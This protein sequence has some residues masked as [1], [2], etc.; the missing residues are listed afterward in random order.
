MKKVML[1]IV[2]VEDIRNIVTVLA[3]YSVIELDIQ[4]GRYIVDARSIMGI[5]SLDLLKPVEFIIDSNDEKIIEAV[6]EDVK[7]W[8]VAEEDA[9][10]PAGCG[11]KA[12]DKVEILAAANKYVTG[13]IIPDRYKGGYTDEIMQFSKDGKSVL[14]KGIYSWVWLSDVVKAQGI[15]L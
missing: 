11:F 14:L 12:G 7:K 5:F 1:K 15:L 3:K 6:L 4:Q 8:L 9:D 2:T 13:E 10:P